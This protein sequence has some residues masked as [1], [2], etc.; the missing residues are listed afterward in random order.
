MMS[1]MA[2]G[3]PINGSDGC[4]GAGSYSSSTKQDRISSF[5]RAVSAKPAMASRTVSS[6]LR[7]RARMSTAE[8]G[9]ASDFVVDGVVTGYSSK[10]QGRLADDHAPAGP[11][12]KMKYGNGVGL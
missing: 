9:A 10:G 1:L 7:M 4:A 8:T 2:T 11:E 5:S 12:E 3:S 6:P